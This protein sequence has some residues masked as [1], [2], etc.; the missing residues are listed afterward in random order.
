MVLEN[1][2]S[3]RRLIER[4]L[5]EGKSD[6]YIERNTNTWHRTIRLIRENMVAEGFLVPRHERHLPAGVP[7]DGFRVTKRSLMFDHE[8]NVK[9][10][11]IQTA[12]EHG[13]IYAVPEG[14]QIKGESALLDADGRIIAKWIKTREGQNPETIVEAIKSAFD[15]FDSHYLKI[16]PPAKVDDNILT[17]IPIADWHIGMHSWGKE[18]G[19]DWDL[20]IAERVIGSAVQEVIQRSPMSQTA[21]VLGGGDLLHADNQ[22]NRTFRTGNQLDVDGRY[23]KVIGVATRMLVRTIDLMLSRAENV[24]VRILKGNHDEHSAIAVAY[25]L[26]AWY[27]NEPRVLVDADP[28]LFWWHRFGQV[29]LGATHGHTVKIKEMPSIMAHRRAEDWGAT[30]YRYVHGF[31]LH[32]SAK[33]ATEGHG[34]ISEIHQSP[35]PQDAWHFGAG[36]LSGRS[37]QTITYHHKFGEVSRARVAILDAEHDGGTNGQSVQR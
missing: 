23:Q 6:R 22:E 14:H 27:R 20:K 33:F 36:F 3:K 9:G 19:H 26:L 30:K 2:P 25:F 12:P 11:A 1:N 4:M 18:T 8:G 13:D 32:H 17:L 24:H 5:L 29:F 16:N 7:D 10:E 34:C 31:H 35:V 21:I 37:I 28:S 15:D